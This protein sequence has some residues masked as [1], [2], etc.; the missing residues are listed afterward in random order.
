VKRGLLLLLLVAGTAWAQADLP[1]AGLPDMVVD[2]TGEDRAS[3]EQ[4]TTVPTPCLSARDCDRGFA[5]IESKCTYQRYREATFDGCGAEATSGLWVAGAVLLL[6]RRYFLLKLTKLF[7]AA[8]SSSSG[9][10][11]GDSPR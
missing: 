6:R 4:D 2:S 3:E 10:S 8:A 11:A 1:D 7:F 5:C 9:V